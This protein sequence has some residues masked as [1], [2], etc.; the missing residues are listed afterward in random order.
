MCLHKFG[1]EFVTYDKTLDSVGGKVQTFRRKCFEE[2]G[3]YLPLKYG[4]IDAAA[5][6]MTRMKG[7]EVRK[8]LA[9]RGVGT[10][11]DW[12]CARQTPDDE[13][14]RRSKILFAGL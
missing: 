1:G 13:A 3:G 7:W 5:E 6:I 2:I 10:S 9:N 8:S 14:A 4:G 12:F 11:S